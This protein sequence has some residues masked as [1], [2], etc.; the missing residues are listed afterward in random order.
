MG[1]VDIDIAEAK[2]TEFKVLM[3][4][5]SKAEQVILQKIWE[6]LSYAEIANQ[7]GYNTGYV[8]NIS[9]RLWQSLSH[10]LGEKVTKKNLYPVL[11]RYQ[12]QYAKE[13]KTFVAASTNAAYQS[14]GEA[15]D[16][17]LFY[18]RTAELLKLEQW[19][20]TERCRLVA[21][22]G[23]GGMGKTALS[24]KLAQQ[25]QGKF[26]YLLWRS[27]RDAPPLADLLTESLKLFSAQ[28][29]VSLPETVGGKISRLI[30]YLQKSRC[31]LILDNFD[32]LLQ[33]GK[34]IGIYRDSYEGYGELL[35]RVGEIPHQSCIILTSREKPLEVGALEG[36][37]LP[38]RSLLLSGLEVSA[39]QDILLAKGLFGSISETT[40]LIEYCRGNPLALKIVA[41]SIRDLFTGSITSFLDQDTVIFNGIFK[42][43]EQQIER[44]S[45]LERQVMYWLAINRESVSVDEL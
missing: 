10:A 19:I 17:S 44:L 43:L 15:I 30:E 35:K 13:E 37:I 8:R 1:N 41:T 3:Q 6:G 36:E 26:E 20:V 33:P 28:K 45:D 38:V 23:M 24:V 21:V 22:L 5:L 42:L 14:W 29:E 25:L 34:R 12:Q 40:R 11:R 7:A 32:A 9:C 31:L 2:V 4:R 18:G 27:L 39:G 16:V